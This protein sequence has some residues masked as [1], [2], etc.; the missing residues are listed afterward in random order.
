MAQR[1]PG[2]SIFRTVRPGKDAGGV[3]QEV[4]PLSGSRRVALITGGTRGF[5]EAIATALASD[6]DV[7]ITGRHAGRGRDVCERLQQH[8]AN[9]LFIEADLADPSSMDAAV[10]SCLAELG[11]LDVAVNNAGIAAAGHLLTQ[12]E[13]DWDDAVS[14]NLTGIWRSLRAELRVMTAQG[15]GSVV[16]ISSIWGLRG[17]AG[18]SAYSA[19]KHAVIGLT[20]SAALDVAADGVRV[21]AVCPG[22]A[23]T[24]MARHMGRTDSDLAALA[25]HYPMGRLTTGDDVGRAVRWLAGDDAAFVTGECIRVD[26]GFSA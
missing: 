9:A 15:H 7:A 14:I 12:S 25:E 21:N 20:K 17:R 10:A 23:D 1:L 8:S 6:M 11:R 2:G 26:G 22:A 16:N 3:R 4:R 18:M 5:G 13:Q 19:T 24:D